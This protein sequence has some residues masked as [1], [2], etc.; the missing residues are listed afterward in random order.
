MS[1]VSSEQFRLANYENGYNDESYP[2]TF[3]VAAPRALSRLK[4][5]SVE[6]GEDWLRLK[7]MSKYYKVLPVKE[8]LNRH[9]TEQ[10]LYA[11]PQGYEFTMAC[12]LCEFEGPVTFQ[13]YGDRLGTCP[14]CKT[15]YLMNHTEVI[16]C[17]RA[18]QVWI[19]STSL[20][21]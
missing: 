4:F 9:P 6:A 15:V 14:Y 13:E 12:K 5:S 7:G 11:H 2:C 10:E 19:K 16:G 3:V 1:T 21:W 20:P 18:R 17:S 8:V